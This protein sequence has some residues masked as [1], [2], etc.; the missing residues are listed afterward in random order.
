M[1]QDQSA[2]QGCNFWK[3]IGGAERG[4]FAQG[5]IKIFLNTDFT[6]N[7]ARFLHNIVGAQLNIGGVRALPEIYL[8]LHLWTRGPGTKFEV[9]EGGKQTSLGFQGNPYPKL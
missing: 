4:K 7:L 8:K 3:L 5:T 6:S 1:E 2:E 9:G